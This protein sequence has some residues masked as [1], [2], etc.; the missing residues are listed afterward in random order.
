MSGRLDEGEIVRRFSEARKSP[1]LAILEGFH[2][3]KHATR[4][5]ADITFMAT[6]DPTQVAE[7]ASSLAP[8]V[9]ERLANATSVPSSLLANLVPRAPRTGLLAIAV[10]P[11][12]SQSDVL[13][14]PSD[15]PVVLLEDP[16]NFG[17]LGACIRVAAAADAAGVLILGDQDPWNPEAIRGAAGLHWAVPVSS[18]SDLDLGGRAVVAIDPDGESLS[19]IRLP[20]RP[21]FAFGTE[22]HGLSQKL[23]DRADITV[24]I[25]MRLGVSSLNLATSVAAVLYSPACSPPDESSRPSNTTVI[26][27]PSE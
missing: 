11:R 4:F 14:S 23:L 6:D 2:A 13:E 7:L 22:R 10:R 26:R 15:R 3:I 20:L 17:N 9:A 16:R 8:D 1:R 25:P 18:A 24:R 21:I 27:D 5:G 19:T 12:V